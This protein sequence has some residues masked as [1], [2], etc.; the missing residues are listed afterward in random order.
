MQSRHE[1]WA[2]GRDGARGQRAGSLAARSADLAVG[3]ERAGGAPRR[4]A[5]WLAVLA[6]CL[7]CAHVDHH[8]KCPPAGD[9]VGYPSGLCAGYY[10]TCWR[11]WPAEC[12]SC[13]VEPAPV[14]VPGPAVPPLAPT[15]S[16]PGGDY[17][18]PQAAPPPPATR[19]QT[20]PAVPKLPAPRAAGRRSQP[21]RSRPVPRIEDSTSVGPPPR[22]LAQTAFRTEVGGRRNLN[23]G[24]SSPA[25]RVVSE[26][27]P[28]PPVQDVPAV[29]PAA[30]RILVAPLEWGRLIAELPTAGTVESRPPQLRSPTAPLLAPSGPAVRAAERKPPQT[31]VQPAVRAAEPVRR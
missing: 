21:I 8:G 29:R 9:C 26:V 31:S 23:E 7:G 1:G 17:F 25:V 18:D 20:P 19:P 6:L 24:P 2:S 27:R 30:S 12:P 13:P 4:L 10:P 3:R 5:P 15:E 22:P 16:V 11:L 28:L 14:V